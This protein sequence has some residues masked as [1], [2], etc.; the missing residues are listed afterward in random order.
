MPG[1]ELARLFVVIDAKVDGFTKQITGVKKQLAVMGGAM[2]AA[3]VAGLKLASDA[4]QVN[5]QLGQLAITTG[6]SKNQLRDMVTGMTD[7][8]TS[9]Q[10][11]T[12]TLTALTR[13]GITN[14]SQLEYSAKAFD[15]LGDAIG[16]SADA[17]AEMLVPA[18]KALGMEIPTSVS[19]LDQFTWL[20]KNTQ[21]E[22]SDFASA[23]DYI[24]I[25]GDRLNISMEQVI[26]IL[27]ILQDR[28]IQGSRAMRAFRG[29][30]IEATDSNRSL[31]DVLNISGDELN[32]YI[33]IIGT[34]A[35]GATKKY[36]DAAGEQYGIMA[37]LKTAWADIALKMGGAL[38]PIEPLLTGMTAIGTTMVALSMT[39]IPQLLKSFTVLRLGMNYTK[40]A[41]AGMWAGIT[42]GASLVITG[43]I[44]LVTHWQSVVDFFRGP[45]YRATKQMQEAMTDLANTIKDKVGNALAEAQGDLQT[46]I[47]FFQR[48]DFKGVELLDEKTL[49][50]L[51]AVNPELAAQLETIQGQ[52]AAQDQLMAGYDAL[53]SATRKTEIGTRLGEIQS[54]LA[55]PLPPAQKRDLL[56]EQARLQDELA[57]M[58]R[59]T[60]V[61]EF[62]TVLNENKTA[63]S[64]AL[65]DQQTEWTTYFNAI[66]AGWDGTNTYLQTRIIP[67]F[68]KLVTE[69][70]MTPQIAE[71]LINAYN[72]ALTEI[73]KLQG[74]GP[75]GAE[76]G[77]T[78]AMLGGVTPQKPGRWISQ[79][80]FIALLSQLP[81]GAEGALAMEPTLM[82]VAEKG[83]EAIIP[84]SDL[85][86]LE[87]NAIHLHV[88]TLVADD[89]SLRQLG[90]K[91]GQV[92]Q[93]QSRRNF[94][95]QVQKGYGTGTSSL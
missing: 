25:Y 69:G 68:N 21:V 72:V 71:N 54:L 94:F 88:G 59:E 61:A 82:H 22:L 50:R 2:I 80:D 63:I 1:N 24:A 8:S 16:L 47:E 76:V 67:A 3:G 5:A 92:M 9:I 15:A 41:A 44:E 7:V 6:L 43:I 35:A 42:L 38:E 66:T 49:A 27:A 51:R 86:G 85:A 11:I 52:I 19:S 84:M 32:N 73:G 95:G 89:F 81:H 45:A 46:T 90:R 93:E 18:F 20:V 17:V 33:N 64:T 70:F 65:I 60:L 30:I 57:A 39:K 78:G 12:A 10:E 75:V 91:L 28:G 87:G 74:P 62:Q 26:G 13:A 58:T 83:P 48:A 40:L 4:R 29:A 31:N 23:M 55:R 79:E 14:A 53:Q 56:A 34:E 77:G 37:K 36:A